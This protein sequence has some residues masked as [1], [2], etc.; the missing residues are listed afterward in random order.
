MSPETV[1]ALSTQTHADTQTDTHTHRHTNTVKSIPA[2]AVVAGNNGNVVTP[3][4]SCLTTV[5]SQRTMNVINRLRWS[6]S[7]YNDCGVMIKSNR[8]QY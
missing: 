5:P 1:F 8:K 4:R 3:I 2:F 7:V 6:H